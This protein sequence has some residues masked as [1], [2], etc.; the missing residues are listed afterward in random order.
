M[1]RMS[2]L[3]TTPD[4]SN[5]F[6][7]LRST[8]MARTPGKKPT[9][10]KIYGPRVIAAVV[11]RFFEHLTALQNETTFAYSTVHDWSTGRADPT[12][13]RLDELAAFLKSKRGVDID[14]LDLLRKPSAAPEGPTDRYTARADAAK[15]LR[16]QV[17]DAAIEDVL[18]AE[19]HPDDVGTW[20]PIEW[21]E[22]MR[23]VEQRLRLRRDAPAQAAAEDRRGAD[24][25]TDAAR[26]LQE[27]ADRTKKELAA[28]DQAR[29]PKKRGTA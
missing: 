23:R 14:P 24:E 13:E 3:A 20:K 1:Q 22:E 10:P 19:Y 2:F 28:E 18:G 15:W 25:V 12:L 6:K 16:G 27:K 5:V 8:S 17:S 4:D 29:T 26:R 7:G 9:G 11:P 21:A